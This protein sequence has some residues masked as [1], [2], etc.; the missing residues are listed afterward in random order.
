MEV[1]EQIRL[2]NYALKK[3]GKLL[4]MKNWAEGKL[5]DYVKKCI[6]PTLLIFWQD[7][8]DDHTETVENG[9][10]LNDLEPMIS[11]LIKRKCKIKEFQLCEYVR[12]EV[13]DLVDWWIHIDLYLRINL[14]LS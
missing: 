3:N 5:V 8:S 9:T 4:S 10:F 11:N 14:S 13:I 6:K 12:N 7:G 1:R 2:A